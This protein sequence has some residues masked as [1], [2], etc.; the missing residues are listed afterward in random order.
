[1]FMQ[2]FN[3][4]RE[5]GTRFVS[6]IFAIMKMANLMPISSRYF[7]VGFLDMMLYQTDPMWSPEIITTISLQ[8]KYHLKSVKLNFFE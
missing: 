1:M 7:T 3:Y 2:Y 5:V 8:V 4:P 6:L